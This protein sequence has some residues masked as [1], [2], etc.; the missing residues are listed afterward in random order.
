MIAAH[1]ISYQGNEKILLIALKAFHAAVPE[2]RLIVVD[3]KHQPCSPWV[4]IECLLLG[5]EWRESSWPRGGNLREAPAISGVLRE[6]C[7]SVLDGAEIVIKLDPD[8]LITGRSWLD[9]FISSQALLTAADDRG[10]MYGCCYAMRADLALELFRSFQQYPPHG[11]AVE[12]IAISTRFYL[13]HD[14]KDFLHIP[15]WWPI[16]DKYGNSPSGIFT[17]WDWSRPSTK[18]RIKKAS[19]FEILNCGI[20]VPKK[21]D[22]IGIMKHL[23]K[24]LARRLQ[25]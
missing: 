11:G 6:L 16:H 1:F 25:T 2:A 18:E 9:D 20:R 7:Q 14:E 4:K 23:F 15:M 24:A 22:Q 5:A 3:D 17:A 19:R 13:L 21:G 12:D 10:Y 8:T